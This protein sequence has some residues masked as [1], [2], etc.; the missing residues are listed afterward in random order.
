MYEYP[1]I[2]CFGVCMI[3]HTYWNIMLLRKGKYYHGPRKNYCKHH[4][5]TSRTRF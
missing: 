1:S 5:T 3:I 4:K 2:I